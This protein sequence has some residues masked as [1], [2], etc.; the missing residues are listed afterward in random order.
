MHEYTSPVAYSLWTHSPT[1]EHIF[2]TMGW[3]HFALR[4]H[5]RLFFHSAAF[6]YNFRLQRN[7]AE[8]FREDIAEARRQGATDLRIHDTVL[9][10]ANFSMMNR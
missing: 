1:G 6:I 7:S 10:A 5:L 3:E 8:S 2:A 4:L 9:I